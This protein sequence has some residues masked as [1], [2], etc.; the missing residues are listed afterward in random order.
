MKVSEL[1]LELQKLN[2]DAII[3]MCY[4]SDSFQILSYDVHVEEKLDGNI[5]EING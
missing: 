2:P 4:S 1:I 5:V 3:S